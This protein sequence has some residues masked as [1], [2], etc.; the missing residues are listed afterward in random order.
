MKKIIAA[1]LLAVLSLTGCAEQEYSTSFYAMDTFMTIT[2]Y[3]SK[4][5]Q[6][7]TEAEQYINSLEA[8]I[9]RTRKN[10]E[11]SALA[12]GEP[13]ELSEDTAELLRTAL[14][15][16]EQTDGRFDPTVAALSDLWQIGKEGQ[17]VPDSAD[18][19]QALGTVGYQNI[20]L[21]GTT[22]QMTGG[23]KLDLGGIGKG[24]AADRTVEIL[25]KNGV[26]RAVIALGG[27]I[28]ALGSR[29]RDQ[30][31]KIGITDPDKAEEYVATVEI[32]DIS[33]VT[34][35]D[36]ERY[37]EQDG[38]RYHHVFDPETGYPAE[39]DLRSVTVVREQSA[40]ADALSTALFVMGYEAAAE[41]CEQ[42]DIAAVFIRNDHTIC[43][44]TALEK[45][46]VFEVTSAEYR[47]EK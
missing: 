44:S 16:A 41:Y 22:A 15:M 32:S 23:A 25:K 6:A 7:A 1:A 20:R 13:A 14:E 18:I 12:G 36:Y 27:N 29:S 31:W 40:Q 26:K 38:K 47:Y 37:F 46:A 8:K 5:Q 28:Y 17:R 9:S 3:G 24:Y 30:G 10:S 11:L 45:C 34:T 42:N 21:D 4:A 35:G 2:A 39:S 43:T 19:A 33:V